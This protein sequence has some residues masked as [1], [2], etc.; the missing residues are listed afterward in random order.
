L[1]ADPEGVAVI[2]EPM[3]I[4]SF[5][6]ASKPDQAGLLFSYDVVSKG[7]EQNNALQAKALRTAGCKRLFEETASGGCWGRPK[8][9]RMPYQLHEGDTVVAWKLDRLSRSLKD[10]LHIMERIADVGAG[11]RSVTEN[12]DTIALAGRMMMQM[13]GSFEFERAMIQERT[14]AGLA[15]ARAE[16]RIGGRRKKLDAAKR[17]E[18]A[19]S[20][21]T[22]RK[23]GADMARLYNISQPTVSRIVAM[24]RISKQQR[25]AGSMSIVG[26]ER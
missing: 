17:R 18:I 15:A 10:V 24:H 1:E 5:L 16:G 12:I 26:M 6:K 2:T 14:S 19:E 20:V 9:H 3:R 8:L 4:R 25:K 7:D 23:S 11:F 22:E 21:I 13:V